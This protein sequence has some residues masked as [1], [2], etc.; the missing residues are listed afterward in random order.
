[1]E[2][3]FADILRCP[4]PQAW[5]DAAASHIDILLIDHKNCEYKAASNALHLMAKYPIHEALV[6]ALSRLAREEL[7]HHEQVLRILKKRKIPLKALAASG[8]ASGLRE[9]VRK[10]EPHQ[11]V[12]LLIFS[13]F[14]EAR[15]CERFA[16]VAP[17]LD[18][19]LS[20]YYTR[21]LK[22][23]ARHYESFLAL[24]HLYGDAKDI[25]ERI[26]IFGEAEAALITRFDPYFR[27][28]SGVPIKTAT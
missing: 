3:A 20:T 16:A 4:T 8:Y 18:A 22:S 17:H 24:A 27:F 6:L 19:E 2:F 5:I 28:H 12:D 25:A 15:S 26:A 13:A 7:V 1:M 11:L 9:N 14:I 10:S 21:L 23:E